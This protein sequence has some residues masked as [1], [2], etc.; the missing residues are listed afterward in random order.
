MAT[1]YLLPCSC[2]KTVT[3]EQTQAGQWVRCKCGAKRE[4]PTLRG[5]RQL[6]Q[7]QTA[8]NQES[9]W[10]IGQ[11]VVLLSLII[12]V[13]SF[14]IGIYLM[15][16]GPKHPRKVAD[17]ELNKYIK[18]EIDK[19]LDKMT[20]KDSFEFWEKY[21]KF[22]LKFGPTKNNIVLQSMVD[23]R[24]YKV[25]VSVAFGLGIIGL[26]VAACVRFSLLE[27][28]SNRMGPSKS[29]SLQK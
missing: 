18:E 19:S 4:V 27:N 26:L 29:S 17:Q 13:L 22:G 8:T 6:K 3:V 25:S 12:A 28:K 21:K 15:A 20:L 14:G 24:F 16:T 10:N 7:V 1:Q 5:L 9:S 23:Y 2:G 11:G